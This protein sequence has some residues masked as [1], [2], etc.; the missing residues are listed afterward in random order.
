M[1][2][3]KNGTLERKRRERKQDRKTEGKKVGGSKQ[4]DGVRKE[5][6][7]TERPLTSIAETERVRKEKSEE[8]E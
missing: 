1:Q 6:K 3:R 7:G 8:K 5:W 4:C 2:G